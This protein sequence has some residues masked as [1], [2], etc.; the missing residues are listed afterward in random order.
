MR[1]R[2]LFILAAIFAIALVAALTL[3]LWLGVATRKVGSSYGVSFAS[4]ERLGYGRFAF[5]DVEVRR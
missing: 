1:R 4:Y 2:L 5:H 3:P